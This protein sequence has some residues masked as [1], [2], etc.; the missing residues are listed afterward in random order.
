MHKFFRL[1]F[2]TLLV[3]AM[4]AMAFGQSTTTGAIGITVSDPQSAV[5][6]NATIT[7]RNIE[8][9]KEENNHS[10]WISLTGAIVR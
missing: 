10:L 1:S 3:F 5:V 4:S 8:T 6:P 2:A 9:N 7:A